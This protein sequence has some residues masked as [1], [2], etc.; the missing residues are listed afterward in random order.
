MIIRSATKEDSQSITAVMVEAFQDF[1]HL[2]TIEAYNATVISPEEVCSRI[3]EGP[4]WLAENEGKVLGTISLLVK[5]QEAYVRGMA[6]LPA[7]QGLG[8]GLALLRQAEAFALENNCQRLF[9][10]TTL[11]LDKAIRFYEQFGFVRMGKGEESFLGTPS[12][13]MEKVYGPSF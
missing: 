12:F 3:D 10:I 9:L 2:Y 8:V 4:L 5:A 1:K 7:A 13:Q 11:Y 6:V